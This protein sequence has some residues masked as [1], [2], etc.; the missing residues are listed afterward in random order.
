[1]DV[2]RAMAASLA[3][4]ATSTSA[5][6]VRACEGCESGPDRSRRPDRSEVGVGILLQ[7][8]VDERAQLATGQGGY[9]LSVFE[10]GRFGRYF[11]MEAGGGVATAVDARGNRRYDLDFLMPG[12][13]TYITARSPVQLYSLVGF[14]MTA[15]W[16]DRPEGAVSALNGFMY[17]GGVGGLGLEVRHSEAISFRFELLAFTRRRF[18]VDKVDLPTLEA[19]PQFDENTKLVSGIG[20]AAGAVFF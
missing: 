7:K 12:F 4:L 19:N 13:V 10:H 2:V 5:Y 17:V 3:L 8:L 6:V 1:M 14:T 18:A 9:G 16:F 11:G 15:T 20:F